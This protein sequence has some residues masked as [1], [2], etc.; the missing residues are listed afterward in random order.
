MK[1]Y[2]SPREVLEAV[3]QAL[4]PRP[5]L[6]EHDPALRQNRKHGWA[7]RHRERP[8]D[9]I[10]GLLQ[11]SRQYFAVTIF[12]NTGEWLLRAASAGPAARCDS[13]RRG[14]GN[15]GEAAKSGMSKVVPDVARDPQYFKVFPETRSELVTPIKI[16][17]HVIG[18]I[19]CESE[20]VNAFAFEDRVLLQEIAAVLARFLSG[21][22]KY[23]VM[24]A[25]EAAGELP[26]PVAPNPGARR[27]GQPD[28]HYDAKHPESERQQPRRAAAGEKARS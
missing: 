4:A 18:V 24:K 11:S 15:V 8:L 21:R 22:G 12:L 16:G 28:R 17:T 5:R 2:R 10:A 9:A 7:S 19:D 14:E 20:R 23:L 25:R 13:M 6:G 1:S 26:H 3:E 27:V